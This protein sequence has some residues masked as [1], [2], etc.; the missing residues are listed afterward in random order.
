MSDQGSSVA[1][2][3]PENADDSAP[4]GRGASELPPVRSEDIGALLDAAGMGG[5][6]E[7][8]E[9][10]LSSQSPEAREETIAD[11]RKQLE[12]MRAEKE[13]PRVAFDSKGAVASTLGGVYIP[14]PERAQPAV[15]AALATTKAEY[16]V[17]V[18]GTPENP[19]RVV[20]HPKLGSGWAAGGPVLSSLCPSC[21]KRGGNNTCLGSVGIETLHNT[22]RFFA[23][24]E[25]KPASGM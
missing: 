19:L 4:S 20:N 14:P 16:P 22:A 9:K 23:C 7:Q 12:A 2:E 11:L 17:G 10:S 24:S 8:I 5:A 21:R 18:P 15:E 1:G 3:A 13:S 25:Y 6:R